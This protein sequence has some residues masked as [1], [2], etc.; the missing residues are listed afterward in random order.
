MNLTDTENFNRSKQPTYTL[1][2]AARYLKMPVTTLRA[3][4]PDRADAGSNRKSGIVKPQLSFFDLIEAHMLR[5]LRSKRGVALDKARTAIAHAEQAFGIE[6]LLSSRDLLG[7][8]GSVFLDRYGQLL[9]LKASGRFAIRRM[10]NEHL[11]RIEWGERFP[12]RLYPY[13]P[14]L[15]GR[16]VVIDPVI[17]FGRPVLV[18]VAVSTSVIA[19]RIDSGEA[20]AEISGDYGLGRNEIEQA[21]VYEHAS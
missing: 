3:W 21:L 9:D 4:W 1:A 13:V 20:V 6:R 17:R 18:G 10:F 15:A 19:E 11:D 2:E 16:P 8:A 7:E 14:G 12:I 5:A